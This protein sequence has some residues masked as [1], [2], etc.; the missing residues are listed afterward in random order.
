M[1]WYAKLAL[2]VAAAAVIPACSDGGG[3][4]GGG[5][6]GI[7]G[8][9]ILAKGGTGTNGDGGNAGVVDIYNY[10]GGDLKVLTS[11]S[12]NTSVNVPSAVPYLGMNPRTL[13]AIP[14]ITVQPL[15]LGN[16]NA[17]ILGDDG[18]NPAT[19]IWVKPGFTVTLSPNYDTSGDGTPATGTF[20]RCY[21]NV[22]YGIYVEGTVLLGRQDSV[23]QGDGLSLNAA[24]LYLQ[25]CD[26]IVVAASGTIDSSGSDNA[27]GAGGAGGYLYA[28]VYGTVVNRGVI[29]SKGGNGTT[30]G[31]SGG[32]INIYST[33]YGIYNTGT[34]NASG[35]NATAGNGGDGGAYIYWDSD[36]GMSYN[37]GS[38][39]S[40]G[41]NGTTGGGDGGYIELYSDAVGACVNSG[42]I[43]TSGGNATVSGNGG[44]S[45][46]IYI[47]AYSGTF[48]VSGTLTAKGGNAPASG[49]G[50][51]YNDYWAVD[52]ENA[53]SDYISD[54]YVI[55]GGAVGANI[56]VAGGDGGTGGDG[57][58]VYISADQ[59]YYAN[60]GKDTLY[61]VGY[62]EINTSGGNGSVN[63]GA[64][65]YIEIYSSYAEDDDGYWMGS[66]YNEVPLIA[67]GGNGT[68][69]TGGAGGGWIDV[70]E[71]TYDYPSVVNGTVTWDRTVTNTASVDVRG[72]DGATGG[73]TGGQIWFYAY[74]KLV[75][76]G[77]M[78]AVGGNTT[79]GTGGAGGEV[80]LWSDDELVNNASINANAG[81]S[82]LGGGGDGDYIELYA[83]MTTTSGTLSCNGGNGATTAGDGGYIEIGFGT[84]LPSS[85]SGSL[86]VDPGT[87]AVAGTLGDIWIDGIHTV[88]PLP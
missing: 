78:N 63:G 81:S 25:T 54:N 30:S 33:S 73:G 82:T 19:G 1:K 42:T 61:V 62:N 31:G 26:N 12:V 79:S 64:G 44:N 53:Y 10:T 57:A 20:E 35:G 72:G 75:N 69:G 34:V 47:Y 60:P 68:T 70:Y 23:A 56:D 74:R 7:S 48:R 45:S 15:P 67:R 36:Y 8:L 52:I 83:R 9:K 27:A 39:L 37:S 38:M 40:V 2:T 32:N 51:T 29:T 11:G 55:G 3:S 21:L 22:Q 66:T 16:T 65:D 58:H 77:S 46:Q 50:G 14:T 41:G 6:A 49:T 24:Q 17:T 87:G 28:P 85:V 43:N 59:S 5:G 4:S 80:E 76:S 86:T 71:D 18:V 84:E 13:F 88:G